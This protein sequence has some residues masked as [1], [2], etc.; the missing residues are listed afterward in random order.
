[1]H[2]KGPGAVELAFRVG[3]LDLSDSPVAGSENQKLMDYT[4]GVNWHLTRN[5]R[6]ML[7]YVY[8][9]SDS[10]VGDATAVLARFQIDF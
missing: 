2:G 3:S 9:D 7:N 5:T 6:L 1:L 10:D 8:T 4:L